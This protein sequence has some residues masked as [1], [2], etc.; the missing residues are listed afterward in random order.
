MIT[1]FEEVLEDGRLIRFGKPSGPLLAQKAAFFRDNDKL[2]ANV[3]RVCAIYSRQP[4]RTECKNCAHALRGVSF[5]KLGVEY[6][7][8]ENCGH[9]NGRN[10]DSEEFCRAVYTEDSGA[11][12]AQVYSSA[13][14]A[15]Y[16]S[17]VEAIYS[18]KAEFLLETLGRDALKLH[19]A[20]M[21]AGSGYFVAALLRAGA[22]NVEGYE[23]SETQVGL[24]RQ[25]TGGKFNIHGL[26][27]IAEIAATVKA[28]V[29][30]F[31]G[32]LE[33]LRNPREVLA[34][35][36]TNAAIKYVYIS[37]PMF[38]PTVYFESIF[39]QVFH[40]HLGAAHTHLYTESSLDWLCKEFKFKRAGEWWFGTDM[41][42]IYRDVLISLSKQEETK[43]LG[44][45]WH[46]AFCN[47]I[48]PLQL[49]LDKR[50][51]SSEVHMVLEKY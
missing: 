10:E 44:D 13:D 49:E 45:G 47:L 48:D 29:I 21:G 33:H 2:H 40:R 50:K 4:H 41:V 1:L 46:Q 14:H 3:Q 22:R 9:L 20:D 43:G 27:Q 17:R 39:P 25:M 26:D 19:F 34:A 12:Y 51:L 28:E 8:C 15:A 42:D 30:S 7:Q 23:V 24:A 31:I 16:D 11:A 38:S 35:I 18:P 5:Q 32:V 6:V 37:V 36:Q